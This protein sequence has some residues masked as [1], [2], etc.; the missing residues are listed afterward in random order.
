MKGAGLLDYGELIAHVLMPDDRR[1]YD[2]EASGTGKATTHR[3][4]RRLESQRM[5]SSH[6]PFLRS[7]DH[8][9]VSNHPVLVLCLAG[10]DQLHLNRSLTMWL[11]MLPPHQRGSRTLR[12][13]PPRL[14]A[15]GAGGLGFAPRARA[16]VVGLD[17]G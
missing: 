8:R 14:L 12:G 1:Y 2:L 10:R 3:L 13:D 16:P 15:A 6:A 4:P 5:S 17:H 11:L 9:R 7:R